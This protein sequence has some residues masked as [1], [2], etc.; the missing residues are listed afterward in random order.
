MFT[1]KWKGAMLALCT[2]ALSASTV[3]GGLLLGGSAEK[4]VINPIAKY[5][6]KDST[7]PGKDSMGNYDL[8]KMSDSAVVTAADGV[9]TFNGTGGLRCA[10]DNDI[11]DDVKS[12]T[13]VYEIQTPTTPSGWQTPVAMGYDYDRVSYASFHMNNT[14]FRLALSGGQRADGKSVLDGTTNCYWGASIGT[15]TTTT[16]AVEASWHKITLSVEVGGTINIYFDGAKKKTYT[17]VSD[18]FSLAAANS[19]FTLG[20]LRESSKDACNYTGNLKNVAVYDFAMR[21]AEVAAYWEDGKLTTDEKVYVKSAAA[22]YTDTVYVAGDATDEEVLVAVS[23]QKSVTVTMSDDSTAKASVTWTGVEKADGKIYAVGTLSGVYNPN[24]VQVKAQ[25]GIDTGVKTLMP[26]AKYEFL[27]AANPGKDSMGNYHLEVKGA[28]GGKVTVENGVATFDGTAGLLP[29]SNAADI[30]EKLTAY[31]LVFKIQ[32]TTSHSGWVEPIGFG[33]ND[34]SP[35]MYGHFH[36]SGGSNMLRFSTATA[37]A[38]GEKVVEGLSNIDGTDNQWWGKEIGNL[39]T[40]KFEEVALSV[41]PGG[42]ITVYLN[43]VAKYNYDCPADYSMANGNMRFAIGCD[44]TW[45][46]ARNYFIGSLKDVAIYDFAMTADQIDTVSALNKIKTNALTTEKY[47]SAIDTANVT[48]AA[49]ELLDT[50][51]TDEMLAAIQGKSTV[52]ATLSDETTKDLAVNWATVTEADGVYTAKG[53]VENTGIGLPTTVGRTEISYELPVEKSLVYEIYGRSLTLDGTIDMNFYAVLDET[54]LAD[55]TAYMLFTVDGEEAQKVYVKDLTPCTGAN[56]K[57]G[58][59]KFKIALVAADMTKSVAVQLYVNGEAYGAAVTTTVQEYA[60]QLLDDTAT[61]AKLVAMI[62][63]MLN[64]GA[65]A[66]VQFG[67]K[68]DALANSILAEAD[69]VLTAADEKVAAVA[70]ATMTGEAAGVEVRGVSLVLESM[71]T[72]KF[73]FDLTAAEGVTY[74]FTVNGEEVTAR[75]LE[76]GR[77][78]VEVEDVKANE[79]NTVYTVTASNGTETVTMTYSALN[80]AKTVLTNEAYGASDALKD[81]ARAVYLYNAAACEYFQ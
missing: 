62:K 34:W 61:D 55:E 1:K 56:C 63:A 25:V 60:K 78:V 74:T 14:T 46:A 26:V 15:L 73:Y 80:Y 3:T 53:Y 18:E 22:D 19:Y 6:F 38:D 69:K 16:D 13:L 58:S 2:L 57:E 30:S 77:Y 11:A 24:G 47:I 52:K 67:V 32:A 21:D 31:T 35:Y 27:D 64:Y 20:Y 72:V 81:L 70:N 44:G 37:N 76:D 71:T 79:L 4:T 33:W 43:G 48:T 51:S 68:T 49:C 50:M 12:F 59:Y 29:A 8:T 28:E 17:N 45:G 54:V 5:E 39:D 36:L 7:N 75:A 42:K 23:S 40:T 41:Q 66:Q 9:A 10:A 65:A